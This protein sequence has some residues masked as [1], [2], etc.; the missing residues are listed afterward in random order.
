MALEQLEDRRVGP[1]RPLK[2]GRRRVVALKLPVRLQRAF[3]QVAEESSVPMSDLGAYFLIRGWNEARFAQGLS[4][5]EMPPYLT[6]AVQAHLNPTEGD[7]TL[8]DSTG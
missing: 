7:Q 5:L 1:G 4:V 2:G 8:L 3:E 6:D